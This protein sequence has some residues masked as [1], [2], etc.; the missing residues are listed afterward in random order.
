[1]ETVGEIGEKLVKQWLINKRWQIIQHR[2]RCRLGEIDLIALPNNSSNS[3]A[4][5]EVKTRSRNN[6]DEQGILAITSQKQLKITQTA[7]Y[8]L[9]KYPKYLDY[10]GRFDV[11][12]VNY[13]KYNLQFCPKTESSLVW[14]NYYFKIQDYLENAFEVNG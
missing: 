7:T 3:L 11:A 5:I 10:N 13:Q 4:F 6:W 9:A 14:N 1:M 12:L 2:W 8:F